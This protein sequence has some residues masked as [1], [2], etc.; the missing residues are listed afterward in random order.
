AFPRDAVAL[1]LAHQCDF[2]LGQS[3]LLR[4]RI[5]RALP[6]WGR[7]EP[8]FGYLQGMHAFGLE[9][10][11]H[12]D[13]AWEAGTDAVSRNARDTWAIHACAHVMEMTGR[14]ADGIAFLE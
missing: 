13:E 14:T 2:L 3:R 5:A 7:N 10:M 11:G 4:D 1:Q 8:T 6:H 9:E 12:Y